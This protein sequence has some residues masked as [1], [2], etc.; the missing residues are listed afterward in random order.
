MSVKNKVNPQQENLAFDT[1]VGDLLHLVT[2]SL[3]S[4]AEIFM[5]ELISN[6][7]DAI[8][9]LRFLS[10]GD[11]ALLS[12]DAQFKIRVSF[13]KDHKTITITDNGVGMTREDVVEHLGTIAKSGTKSFLNA[14][15]GDKAKDSKLIGQFGVGFYSSF[16]VA[17]KVMV[18][19]LKAG[20]ES[21]Q[22]VEWESDGKGSYS[23]KNVFRKQRG[24]EIILFIKDDKKDFLDDY[25]LKSMIKKYSNYVA[26]PI[27]MQ[28]EVTLP[29]EEEA[30]KDESSK[31]SEKSEKAVIDDKDSAG[32]KK[33]DTKAAKKEDTKAAKKEDTKAAKK[34]D[35]KAEKK[36]ATEL[37][38][39]Q[40]N[41]G[42]PPWLRSKSEN[43]DK[44][45][46]E[47]YKNIS[48]DYENPM[49]WSHNKVEGKL[50][51]TSLLYIP[52]RAPF[53]MWQRDNREGLKLYVRQVFIM[54]DAEQLLPNY[55]RFV[56]GIVDSND[57]PL[58]V[59]REILQS[60]KTIDK[61]KAGCVKRVLTMLESMSKD[62]ESKDYKTFW[63]Q[64]GQVIKE[65]VVE[66][67]ANRDKISKL[68]RF[69][70]T[71]GDDKQQDIS[72]DDYVSRMKEGQNTIYY[73]IAE[74]Y[75]A[76]SSSPLLEVFRKKGIE[77]VLLHDRIDEWLVSHLTEYEGKKLQ[78]IAKGAL[79]L[80]DLDDEKESEEVVKEREK[81][82]EDTLKL[83]QETLKGRVKEVRL[84]TRL[85]DSPS[86]VVHDEDGMS[87]HMQRLMSAAGQDM[88]V[89]PP[90]LELNPDHDLVKRL[91]GLTD[92]DVL[93][94]W[95]EMLLT[96]A[97]L[98]EGEQVKNPAAFIKTLN[99]LL[100]SVPEE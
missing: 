87:G 8:E 26:F 18:R 5:R 80:G 17:D 12:G 54:D 70:T 49:R 24:T 44:D 72:L 91:K 59:S 58:N 29:V 2:H 20:T 82:Y 22:G 94:K 14:L 79:D 38:W 96:Q 52:S 95:S 71:H 62:E 75:M 47:L 56:R 30:K 92:K 65:G 83:L 98:S 32:D 46:Q 16:V 99:E 35:E 40:V 3:Y 73:V 60:N 25:R 1:E 21:S 100:V 69:N 88:P 68:L 77:V 50:E 51:Y 33:E 63:E 43:T 97:L 85:T 19:S 15:S 7:S 36:A 41:G 53:D 37:K 10:L 13:D 28:E 66:D 34:E 86:C 39:Q 48:R 89:S 84:S 42:V 55:L 90:V 78:S 6:S 81:T 76:A 74:N 67:F 9:R 11:N 45:Y 27:E 93:G 61:I 57:L 64:F 4:N 31:A 23:I